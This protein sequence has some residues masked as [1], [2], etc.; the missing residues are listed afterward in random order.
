MKRAGIVLCGGRSRR[1]GRS[2]ALLPWFGPTLVEHVVA[3]LAPCV[4][5]VLVVT[6]RD[7][8]I[9]GLVSRLG[10]RSIFDREPARGP[11]AA[12]RD[13]LAATRA[14]RAFVTTTD[15]PFLTA[16]AARAL[17]ER[18]EAGVGAGRSGAVVPRAAGFLQVLSAVYPADAWREAEVLLGTAR[19]GG[20]AASAGAREES[21]LR[22]LER[23]GFDAIEPSDASSLPAWT[24]FNTP[25]EYLAL[26]RGQDPAACASIEWVAGA[27]GSAIRV[28]PIGRLGELLRAVA[29]PGF[30]LDD[31]AGLENLVVA[32]GDGALRLDG[33][34]SADL[35]LPVGPGERVRISSRGPL[36][37]DGR[38]RALG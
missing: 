37:A 2:K 15:A 20:E 36:G 34:Q 16:A 1:M 5:E 12:L 22:L 25:D 3:R 10:A 38:D 9:E 29:P 13:G 14:E 24:S 35:A 17:F 19:A 4:D 8:P 7:L 30:A 33:V 18:A 21:P 6:A 23:I 11:L 31:P 27:A 28:V 26:A 32:F